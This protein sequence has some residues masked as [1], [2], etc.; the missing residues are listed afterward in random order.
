MAAGALDIFGFEFSS[1]DADV[2]DGPEDDAVPGRKV[3]KGVLAIL[4]LS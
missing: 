3:G 2:L 4:F 1:I